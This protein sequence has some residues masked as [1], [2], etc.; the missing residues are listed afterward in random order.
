[1]DVQV[2][3][4]QMHKNSSVICKEVRIVPKH[5]FVNNTGQQLT[6]RQ[7]GETNVKVFEPDER[8]ILEYRPTKHRRAIFKLQDS[9]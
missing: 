6:F 8:K 1:L 7:E 3:I 4:K 2:N 5:V 9:E